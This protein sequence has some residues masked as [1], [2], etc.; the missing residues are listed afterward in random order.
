MGIINNIMKPSLVQRH[1]RIPL[2]KTLPRPVLC[3]GSE[4]WTLREKDESRITANEM[5]F[6]RYTAGYTK[7]NHKCNEDVMEELQQEPVINHVKHYQNNWINHLHRMHRGRIPKVTIVQTGSRHT[8]NIKDEKISPMFPLLSVS[9]RYSPS[10]VISLK[11]YDKENTLLLYLSPDNETRFS[12]INIIKMPR[13]YDHSAH[14]YECIKY[15]YLEEPISGETRKCGELTTD[16]ESSQYPFDHILVQGQEIT[17]INQQKHVLTNIGRNIR[18]DVKYV[19]LRSKEFEFDIWTRRTSLEDYPHPSQS[20]TVFIEEDNLIWTDRRCTMDE[21]AQNLNISHGS[22]YSIIHDQLKYRKVCAKWVPKCLTAVHKW[23]LAKSR[24]VIESDKLYHR[25]IRSVCI[26][27]L[28]YLQPNSDATLRAYL[29]SGDGSELLLGSARAPTRNVRA[30]VARRYLMNSHLEK[31]YL[32]KIHRKK[33][34]EIKNDISENCI[35][36]SVVDET[37]DSYD[38]F[39]FNVVLRKLHGTEPGKPHLILC[40]MLQKTNHSNIT[41]TDKDALQ[42]LWCKKEQDNKFLLLIKD[43][44]AYM[45]KSNP[46]TTHRFIRE[47]NSYYKSAKIRIVSEKSASADVF[48]KRITGCRN[49][50][51]DNVNVTTINRNGSVEVYARTNALGLPLLSPDGTALYLDDVDPKPCTMQSENCEWYRSNSTTV[52]GSMSPREKKRCLR[53]NIYELNTFSSHSS[54]W[55]KSPYPY[56]RWLDFENKKT[57]KSLCDNTFPMKRWYHSQLKWQCTQGHTPETQSASILSLPQSVSNKTDNCDWQIADM[58]CIWVVPFS[59]ALATNAHWLGF[60]SRTH[61]RNVGAGCTPNLSR[62]GWRVGK[63]LAFYAQGCGFDPGP[64]RWH[65]SVLKCDRLM[66]VDLLACKRTPAGQNSG[67]SGNADITSAVASVFGMTF[68]HNE[69]ILLEK[70]LKHNIPHNNTGPKQKTQTIINTETAIQNTKTEH[71]EYIRQDIIRH[72]NKIHE[73]NTNKREHITIKTLK[74]KQQQY[75][76]IFTK[77]DKGNCT[78]ILHKQ[79]LHNK[80]ET[81]F[82]QNDITELEK[83]QTTQYHNTIKNTINKSK[84]VIPYN[85]KQQLKPI[86]RAAPKL[87]ALPKIHK[88]KTYQSDL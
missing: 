35:W 24:G 78:V 41:C 39:T 27:V 72:I 26:S 50:G 74:A 88:E 84:H 65:L 1:T 6:M 62:P 9:P 75:N 87:N 55:A 20:H 3:Y 64:G 67:T 8:V 52:P 42:M 46:W 7:W 33:I 73:P 17:L 47:L 44:A 21:V 19:G 54:G 2:Y 85:M 31:N 25:F 32:D 16:S 81:Y 43:S 69:T 76:L 23:S 15:K 38:R 63:A 82:K 48:V 60:Y 49:P 37:T 5:K 22:V 66:S 36:I 29:V 79:D 40:K 56:T 10:I 45:L 30:L 11:K 12:D 28:Y 70:G 13:Y 80:I 4:A 68:N 58:T 83:D 61:A 77:A 18:S 59:A 86:K 34:E 14:L 51:T 57:G 71:K 53:F